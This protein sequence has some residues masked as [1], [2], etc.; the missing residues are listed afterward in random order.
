MF[1]SYTSTL[2]LKKVLFKETARLHT[3]IFGCINMVAVNF[4]S[5]NYTEVLQFISLLNLTPLDV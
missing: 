3:G 5:Y 1:I 4:I 2:F